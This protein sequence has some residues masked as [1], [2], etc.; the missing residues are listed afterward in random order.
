MG[1]KVVKPVLLKN[2]QIEGQEPLCIFFLPFS[3]QSMTKQQTNEMFIF[4]FILCH[5]LI[6]GVAYTSECFPCK[7][8]T[9]SHIP[10]SSTCEPCPLDTYSGHGASSC[11]PCNTTTQYAGR[12]ER[13]LTHAFSILNPRFVESWEQDDETAVQYSVQLNCYQ[14]CLQKHMTEPKDR[15]R[16]CPIFSHS[17]PTL[18]EETSLLVQRGGVLV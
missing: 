18:E 9:F 3:L 12:Q 2:I 13:P 8:G 10:G 4:L 5:V 11:T 15:K 1:T 6:P 17:S 7:P 16:A 14:C